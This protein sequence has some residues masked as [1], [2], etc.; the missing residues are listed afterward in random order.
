[1]AEEKPEIVN[2]PLTRSPQYR[3]VYVNQVRAGM[4]TWDIQL[5][6]GRVTEIAPGVPAVEE[7]FTAVMAPE[8]VRAVIQVLTETM[9]QFEEK[10]GPITR[11]PHGGI[12]SASLDAIRS[13]VQLKQEKMSNPEK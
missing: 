6:F 5:T 1:M 10:V 9:R 2:A 3:S 11:S 8:Y 13:G 7:Q 4:S 12:E